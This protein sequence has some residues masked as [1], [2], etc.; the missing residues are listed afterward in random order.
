MEISIGV[1]LGTKSGTAICSCC[2]SLGTISVSEYK[3]EKPIVALF[4]IAKLL[5]QPRCPKASDWIKKIWYVYTKECYSTVMKNGIML[6]AG[7][8]MKLETISLSKIRQTEKDK[9][10]V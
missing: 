4:T 3:I 9:Y 10:H 5:N 2:T 7:E 8:C 6:F 1:P